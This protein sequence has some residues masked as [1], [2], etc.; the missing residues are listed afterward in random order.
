VATLVIAAIYASY[1]HAAAPLNLPDD[2]YITYRYVENTVHGRAPVY[3]EG[4]K[5]FGVSTPLYWLWL[6][7]LKLILP[8]V[9]LPALASRGNAVLLLAAAGLAFIFL[10]RL[11]L[12]I[13][14]SALAAATILVADEIL[15]ESIG[16]ME[17]SLFM[18]LVFGTCLAILD[19]RDVLA[20]WLASFAAL[21]RPEGSLLLPV[22]F[23][24]WLLDSKRKDGTLKLL[25]GLAPLI[26]WTIAATL[27]YGTPVPH[28]ILAK[29]RP[30]YPAPPGQAIKA[31][32]VT[33]GRWSLD[34]ALLLWQAIHKTSL[35]RV[36]RS[37]SLE[38]LYTAAVVIIAAWALFRWWKLI[39]GGAPARKLALPIFLVLLLAFYAASN[40]QMMPWYYPTLQAGWLVVV[41]GAAFA[42]G[43]SSR[44][45]KVVCGLMASLVL[46]TTIWIAAAK[47]ASPDYNL[48]RQGSILPDR[49]AM[50]GAYARAADWIGRNSSVTDTVAAGEIG[51][52]GYSLDRRILDSCGLVTP[53]AL[54]FNPV[55]VEQRGQET[56]VINVDFIKAT[57][58]NFVVSLAAFVDPSLLRSSWFLS[59]YELAHQ[60]TLQGLGPRFRA[61][62]VFRLKAPASAAL[63]P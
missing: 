23:A 18:A 39:P 54:P 37:I 42:P 31:A 5:V 1:V 58:P 15:R 30:L 50:M 29:A 33:M 53:E 17:C 8:G 63:P 44:P 2:A 14:T 47:A 60:E 34:G 38:T 12:G 10:R 22:V 49:E 62:F 59:A 19:R 6:V 51:M 32:F 11:G 4:E 41:I 52:L 3:N 57:R 48:V 9:G 7:A 35:E 45:G 28:S 61:V 43:T 27:Y 21:A 26:A 46:G 25:S 13:T 56:V 20:L 36:F 16:G 24:A 55:P 40:P